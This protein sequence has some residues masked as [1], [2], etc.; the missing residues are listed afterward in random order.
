MEPVPLVPSYAQ[1]IAVFY[2]SASTKTG[3]MRLD[4]CAHG[5]MPAVPPATRPYTSLPDDPDDVISIVAHGIQPKPAPDTPSAAMSFDFFALRQDGFHMALSP[6]PDIAVRTDRSQLW[7]LTHARTRW[8]LPLSAFAAPP[9]SSSSSS[10][11]SSSA[12]AASAAAHPTTPT[13][14]SLWIRVNHTDTH[15]PMRI[16]AVVGGS[17]MYWSQPFLALG[18]PPPGL[19]S[20]WV[21]LV[22]AAVLCWG[23]G[24]TEVSTPSAATATAAAVPSAMEPT[25]VAAAA[26]AATTTNTASWAGWTPFVPAAGAKATAGNKT[27]PYRVLC[28]VTAASHIML[29]PPSTLLPQCTARFVELGT[30]RRQS[31]GLG[32]APVAGWKRGLPSTLSTEPPAAKRMAWASSA[33]AEAGARAGAR[34]A[35]AE[36]ID[37]TATGEGDN[38]V[39]MGTATTTTHEDMSAAT[40][41]LLLR[42]EMERMVRERD[43]ALAACADLR[44]QLK[45][46][47][48]QA[49]GLHYA[50]SIAAATRPTT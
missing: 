23:S 11:S 18:K 15:L 45:T 17:L 26:A 39:A 14:F 31:I 10:S 6:P 19:K 35:R 12:P 7:P 38:T 5:G 50:K 41:L 24:M 2:R 1:S 47:Q 22:A 36:G 34:A 4:F 28:A 42:R 43:A 48:Q 20:Q 16:R 8:T 3:V 40:Q 9:A 30:Y 49:A 21:H 13:T 32:L 27:G 29:V 44:A 33:E 46:A 25:T 37:E